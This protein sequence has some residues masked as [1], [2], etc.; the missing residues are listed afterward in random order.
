MH[1]S[2]RDDLETAEGPEVA[3]VA[4]VADVSEVFERSAAWKAA[5]ID[6]LDLRGDARRAAASP[7]P[8]M[9]Q[10]LELVVRGLAHAPPGPGLDLGAGLGGVADW[11]VERTARPWLPLDRSMASCRAL[12]DLFPA[13]RPLVADSDHLPVRTGAAAAVI[14][15]GLV[16]VLHDA[17]PLME[18]CVRVV[19]PG[20]VVVV[21]DLVSSTDED[22]HVGPNVFR[23]IEHIVAIGT[24]LGLV[25]ND[26]AVGDVSV[27]DWAPIGDLVVRELLRRHGGDPSLQPYLDDQ[28]HLRAT[29]DAG[30]V[31]SA[32]I[33]WH[34]P[35]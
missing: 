8:A 22:H 30:L 19:A 32:A 21:A 18:E 16:S 35:G 2:A 12:R 24:D 1:D 26:L 15:S 5:S 17:R 14:A 27:G 11:L 7:G 23:S 31:V 20:G 28:R 6:S 25:A 9:P 13:M 3:E 10:V 4:T 29:M 33:G 34:R